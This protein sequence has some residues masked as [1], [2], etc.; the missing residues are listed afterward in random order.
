MSSFI[1]LFNISHQKIRTRLFTKQKRIKICLAQSFLLLLLLTITVNNFAQGSISNTDGQ[2]PTGLAPGAP[3]GSYPLSGFDSINYH[4][5]SL[6]VSVPLLKVGGRGGAQFTVPLNLKTKPWEVT[7]YASPI[8]SSVPGVIGGYLWY[9]SAWNQWWT[10]I[11]PK[12][13]YGAGFAVTRF[14]GNTIFSDGGTPESQVYFYGTVRMRITFTGADGTEYNF[15]PQLNNGSALNPAGSQDYLN[16]GRVFIAEH[17]A[18][19]TFITDAD[20]LTTGQIDNGPVAVNG[21]MYMADGTRYRIEGGLVKRIVDK[22]GNR[23]TFTHDA[24]GRVLQIT[25]SLNRVVNFSYNVVMGGVYGTG[26]QITYSGFGGATRT[27]RVT[28]STLSNALM[29]G[30]TFNSASVLPEL[31]GVTNPSNIAKT[32]WLPNDQKYEFRYNEFGEVKKVELPTGGK[33]EY[34][35]AAGVVNG[36]ADGVIGPWKNHGPFPPNYQPTTMPGIY[37]RL[38]E[39]RIYQDLNSSVYES[40][41]VIGRPESMIAAQAGTSNEGYQNQGFVDVNV[42]DYGGT[43]QTSA[44]HYFYPYGSPYG[45]ITDRS[46]S[47]VY[48]DVDWREAREIKTELFS[49]S[50]TLLRVIENTLG[51]K[52]IDAI[53]TTLVDSNQVSKQ[54]FLYDSSNNQ[55]D[56]YEY[57]LGIGAPPTY[58]LRHRHTDFLTTNS[59]NGQ[60]YN[61]PYPINP[62]NPVIHLRNLPKEQ[63]VYAV[64]TTNGTETQVASTIFEYDNYTGGDN[65][66]ASLVDR[67]GI[68]GREPGFDT[69]K[70]TRGNTTKVGNWRNTDN[71]Y[72]NAY[73]QYDIAGNVVKTIDAN[74]NASTFEYDDRFGSPNGNAQSNV[75][76][77][78]AP[79]VSAPSGWLAG[80]TTFAFLTK[81]TNAKG[82]IAYTQFDYFIGKPIDTEDPNNVKSSMY[83]SDILDRPTETRRNVTSATAYYSRS[84][85]AYDDTNHVITSTSDK[86]TFGDN[87]LTSKAYYDGLGRTYR[88]ASKEGA[89]WSIK[90]TQFDALGRAF[91]ATNPFRTASPTA[92]LVSPEWTTSTFDALGRVTKVTSPDSAFVESRY[93]GNV[94]TVI[95]QAKKVRRSLTD[96]LGR[97]LR[98]DEPNRDFT[99]AELVQNPIN[100]DLLLGAVGS[101]VQATSYAYDTLDNLT[102]VNQGVQTRSFV[103]DSLKR[104]TSATNPESSTTTYQYD[105]NGNLKIK[106][107]AL[108]RWIAYNYDVLN[109]NYETVSNDPNTVYA[110]H[111][112]DGAVNG[113]GRLWYTYTSSYYIGGSTGGQSLDNTTYDNYDALGRPTNYRQNYAVNNGTAWSSNYT[114]SRTYDLAGNVKSQTYPSGRVVNYNY[115]NAA[116]MTTFTGNLGDG[117]TRNYATG[118]TYTPAG[119]LTQENFGVNVSTA[120]PN[121]IWHNTHYNNRLQMTDARIGTGINDGQGQ[122]WTWNRGAIRLFYDGNNNGNITRMDH[123]V[124][125]SE[126]VSTYAMSV[127]YYGYDHLNRITGIW[128]NKQAHNL[129]ETTTN[130]TQQYTYDRYGNRAVNN[131]VS[132]FPVQ[133]SPY[134]VSPTNNRIQ[135]AGNC[136]TFDA[137]GNLINDCGRTRVYDG[138]NKMIS[139]FDAGVPTSYRY[140]ADGQRTIKTVGTVST[141]YI[142][143]MSGELVA[144][145]PVN[146]AVASPQKEYGYRGAQMLMVYDSTEAGNKQF[147]WL[148][149]DHLGSTRMV[150]DL[151]GTLAGMNLHDYLPFGEEI[152]VSGIRTTAQGYPPPD[153][154]IHQ[155]FT[156]YEKDTETGL[157]YAQARYYANVQGRFTCPDTYMPSADL[158]EPQSWNRY[159]Y[160]LNNPLRYND[161]SGL[162]YSD[163]SPEQRRVFETYANAYNFL[164]G[165]IE[166]GQVP[167][168]AEEVY[169]TLSNSQMATFES[170]THALEH[171]ELHGKDKNK[172]G[173][174]LQLVAGVGI[175][176]G[177][178][179]NHPDDKGDIQ[180]RL[181]IG[182][183]KEAEET[184]KKATEFQKDA[185]PNLFYHREFPDSYRQN[186]G[187]HDGMP[188]VQFSINGKSRLADVDVDF[189]AILSREGHTHPSNSDVTSSHGGINNTQ[190]YLTQWPTIRTWW[191]KK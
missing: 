17:D 18:Q 155:K 8:P 160:A 22:Q 184:L 86:D 67:T 75:P 183:T 95:D 6:N 111:I 134:T 185:L 42:Y 157:D 112:Y 44:K 77:G 1:N 34:D 51:V 79:Y 130:L 72:L 61:T 4:N 159:T 114:T 26:D 81:I 151:S 182:L 83:Y 85:I 177:A 174:A 145:Y 53:K 110:L 10:P 23:I 186:G 56:V 179:S 109:R 140:N 88:S 63:K 99:G 163:L 69:S 178:D 78:E 132:T 16:F 94:V 118:M 66:H 13:N 107:D 176:L 74:G 113:K 24:S 153:D 48:S 59:V 2:T 172:L 58:P 154:K 38:V 97:L 162:D 19:V 103:Y 12:P 138:N 80:Q 14:A 142:Y 55:T 173:N 11:D 37:R 40:R 121:G 25:D 144:E 146:G 45:T 41:E 168:T 68:S 47:V 141:W 187:P 119:Q 131:A 122:E 89:T 106:T 21:W 116:Q 170:I 164:Y 76:A 156:G 124:P 50:G 71:V 189:R 43:K 135:S 175:I 64:N 169:S 101:P 180:Y 36:P 15:D 32:L 87:T 96:G 100:P 136:M 84:T 9:Y 123:F 92:A 28:R 147:Q 33:T 161:P 57:D 152:P 70:T 166:Y 20:L 139:A 133:N 46:V 82:H 171:T 90:E 31:G 49:T 7:G 117:T 137:V 73:S 91:R 126:S 108:G 29:P 181:I 93:S 143:G 5:G 165:N 158:K 35:Y 150:I 54:T 125:T 105:L 190:R 65:L 62:A 30:L 129:G 3:A 149:Q 167:F 39:K 102:T 148:V 115:N 120:V 128:E 98:V 191:V 127:D 60:V 188:S 104:L 52:N 27:I